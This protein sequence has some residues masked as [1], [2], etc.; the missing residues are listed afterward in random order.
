VSI[1][2][3][4]ISSIWHPW[5]MTKWCWCSIIITMINKWLEVIWYEHKQAYPPPP[6]P[7]YLPTYLPIYLPTHPII[8]L[9]AYLPTK[10]PTYLFTYSHTHLPTTYLSTHPSTYVPIYLPLISYF[11]ITYL[12]PTYHFTTCYLPHSL[13]VI[14]NKHVKVK[15]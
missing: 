10:P 5:L 13:V 4:F 8:N 3:I 7:T 11:L 1:F 14:W 12:P 2:I 15:T 6:T 9:L